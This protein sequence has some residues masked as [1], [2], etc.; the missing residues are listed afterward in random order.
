MHRRT[1]LMLMLVLTLLVSVLAG[2]ASAQTVEVVPY[3]VQEGDTLSKIARQFCTTWQEI[4]E[5]NQGIIGTDPNALEP[6][7]L[8]YI[9]PRCGSG[10][11]PPAGGVYDRGP[12]LHANGT[13]QGNVYTVAPGDTLYSIG[14]RFGVDH[15]AIAEA[16]GLSDETKLYPGQKLIIPGLGQGAPPVTPMIA[17]TSPMPG[18]YLNSP[19]TAS[20]TG[21]GLPEGNVVVRLKDGSGNIMAEQATILQGED[22]GTGGQGVWTVTFNNVIGQPYANGAIEAF[23]PGTGALAGVSIWFTGR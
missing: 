22:V 15:T 6:G 19:Y 11:A 9:I 23:S 17:I 4:Y 16:N 3:V 1:I 7:T 14:Q 12:M 13:V 20:G 21:Q 10:G 18:A 8:I 2:A 5:M